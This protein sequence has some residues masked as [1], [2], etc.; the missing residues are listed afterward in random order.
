M[1]RLIAGATAAIALFSL[2]AVAAASNQRDRTDENLTARV[3]YDC[4]TSHTGSLQHTYSVRVLRVALRTM[5]GDVAEYTGCVDAI[6][7]QIRNAGGTVVAGIRMRGR[8]QL[9]AGRLALLDRGGRKVDVIEVE[10]GELA[11]FRVLP[12]RYTI[13]ANG[14]RGCTRSVRVSEWRTATAIIVCRR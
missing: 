12:G 9:A 8:G 7:E 4:A 11:R 3:L 13:R 1:K 14:R 2:M 5:P 10:R 6:R